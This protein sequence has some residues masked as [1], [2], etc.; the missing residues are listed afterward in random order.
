[1]RPLII[2]IGGAHSKAGK[3]KVA[4][5]LLET[6]SGW[7]AIKFT[8]TQLYTSI[9]DTPEVLRQKDKDTCRFLDAGA[10]SVL[11]IKSSPHELRETLEIAI[12]RLSNLKGIIIEGNSPID[13]LKPEIV[14]F[15]SKNEEIKKG[16]ERILE[17]ADVVIFE[18][19]PP[20]RMPGYA[21]RFN[22]NDE[23]GYISFILRLIN[24]KQKLN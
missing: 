20:D 10:R 15:V 24:K 1:M 11:W 22:I 8:K 3:T 9:I 19:N 4:C 5:K 14:V 6:L 13:V 18:T 2:G 16:A 7:G 23:Q 12:E 17:K 21:K